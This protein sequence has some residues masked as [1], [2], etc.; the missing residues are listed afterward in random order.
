MII[1][2]EKDE[3][4][5]GGH[6]HEGT[7]MPYKPGFH[8]DL[9]NTMSNQTN[10]LLLSNF[11]RVIY[12]DKPFSF[13]VSQDSLSMQGDGEIE[14][15]THGSTLKEAY[16]YAMKTY[17]PQQASTVEQM[18][19]TAPQFNTWIELIYNQNQKDILT[20]AEKIVS[21]GFPRGVLMIDD[22]WQ[23]DYGVWDF[24]PGRFP[25]AK[26]M[27]RRL[28]ELGFQVMLWVCPFVSPDS[29]TF[30]KMEKKHLFVMD[31]SG[32]PYMVKWW[33][34]YSAVLDLS[35]P[36][37]WNWFQMQMDYLQNTYGVDGF[38][39]DAGAPEYY[40]ADA[41]YFEPECHTFRQTQK[42][43]EFASQYP[44]SEL[45]ETCNQP[46]F[47]AAQRLSDKGHS[48]TENGLAMLI[49]NSIAQSIMGYQFIC[50]DMIGGGEY[51]NMTENADKLDQELLIRSTQASALLPMMQFSA[52]P[53]R[54]MDT[55]HYACCRKAVDLHTKFADYILKTVQDSLS[56]REPV[57]QPMEYAFAH[58]G[59]QWLNQQFMLGEK[60]LV[61][62]VMEKGA[63]TMQIALPQGTWTADDGT[64]YKGNQTIEIAVSLDRLPYFIR[65]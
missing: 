7:Q 9:H 21:E 45:R 23:E 49:P 22:N 57:V 36:D 2:L 6:V 42:F 16:L 25:D 52:A 17:Y 39:F 58:Q 38:K 35:N 47:C 31:A 59:M 18:L 61:A 26:S 63:T 15:S 11:G 12:S 65:G 33:N 46:Q 4:F 51:S 64:V 13:T 27:I 50:P 30:R 5:W 37:T 40:P 19:F 48:W 54:I 28:H 53:W 20:Y 55:Q 24:H 43:T 34:G 1:K 32:E 3:C 44:F 56:S 41:V 60:L 14:V 8:A 62:P 29:L 10:Y